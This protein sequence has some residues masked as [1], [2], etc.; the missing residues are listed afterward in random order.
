[1]TEVTVPGV[2]FLVADIFGLCRRCGDAP[3]R[4]MRALCRRCYDRAWHYGRLDDYPPLADPW[5][6]SHEV[7]TARHEARVEDFGYLL[8]EGVPFREAC[9]RIGVTTRT[10]LRYKAILRARAPEGAAA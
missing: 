1:V 3:R 6:P 10:G 2:A 8:A 7:M 9:R 5:V 4:G